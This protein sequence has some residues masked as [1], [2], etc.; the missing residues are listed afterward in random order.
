MFNPNMI[1][2]PIY[3]NPQ[4]YVPNHFNTSLQRMGQHPFPISSYPHWGVNPSWGQSQDPFGMSPQSFGPLQNQQQW[5]P[6]PY[7]SYGGQQ[8]YQQ[9][10]FSN[11]L[12]PADMHPYSQ[13]SPVNSIPNFHQ[14]PKNSLNPRPPSGMQSIMNS[15]KAQDGS[16]D[17]N[18]MID[19]AGQMMNAVTQVSSMVKGFG[20]M[21][22][23]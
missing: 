1:Y 7:H 9:S 15:F 18:K 16:L 2:H 21:F 5:Y 3:T 6:S 13:Q 10:I 11:P 12:Q 14:Y 4:R 17:L 22:K 20:G 19:T 23:V 8:E